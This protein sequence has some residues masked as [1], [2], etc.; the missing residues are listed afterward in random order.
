MRACQCYVYALSVG[1]VHAIA[2]PTAEAR[3][4]KVM[5]D[6]VDELYQAVNDPRNA[7]TVVQVRRGV[8]ALAATPARPNDGRLVLQ[9]GMELAGENRYRFVDGRPAPRDAGGE[10]FADPA[11]ETVLD[12][13][14]LTGGS[15]G[16]AGTPGI[17]VAGADNTV[18]N[19]TV[20]TSVTAVAGIEVPGSVVAIRECI[21]EAGGEGGR[22]GIQIHHADAASVG[23]SSAT[24]VERNVV[25]HHLADFGFGIQ[26]V[27]AE[28]RDDLML[29]TLNGNVVYDNALGLFVPNVISSDGTTVVFS[30]NNEY[31]HNFVGVLVI[32]S[33]DL[34]VGLGGGDG[35]R[36]AV[37]SLGDSITGNVDLPEFGGG[38]GVL[39]VAG[40]GDG[41]DAGAASNDNLV[42]LS[43]AG[44][45]FVA[46]SGIQNGASDGSFRQDIQV[47]GALAW[48]DSLGSNNVLQLL[49]VGLGASPIPGE[50]VNVFALDGDPPG[51]NN[52]VEWVGGVDALPALN[53]LIPIL[54]SP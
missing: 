36:V 25:R 41:D 28:T 14:A 44:T 7:N 34:G 29:V 20:R 1:I 4:R 13:S 52:R 21:L 39:A 10:V 8:Y 15:A 42:A 6:D 45:R 46:P 51:R 47:F 27:R 30:W 18:R 33:R 31:R 17:I 16:P 11:S 37:T 54:V 22:R 9:P 12:G 24:T 50:A 3:G 5:V 23:S 35:N 38:V 49:L 53:P 19:L 48:P 40:L 32:G 2:G 26:T 43:F